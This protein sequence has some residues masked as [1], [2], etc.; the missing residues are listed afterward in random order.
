MTKKYKL[1][2]IGSPIEHSLS[3][4]IQSRFA[5]QE[6]IYI[7]YRPFK[8]E[9]DD[10]EYFVKDFFAD[11]SSKGLNVTLPLKSL[12]YN[13]KG[14]LSKE[15]SQIQAVNTIN[16][17]DRK[18]YLD[19]TDGIGFV[20]DLNRKKILLENKNVLIIG[21][22][23]AV[24]S[25]LFN[26]IQKKPK[27]IF[28]MN[29]TKS[30][31]AK[32]IKKYDKSF[33]LNIFDDHENLFDVI[34]NGSSAGLTGEFKPPKLKVSNKPSFYDLNYSLTST[35]FCQW[36]KEKSE[37]VFDGTGMLVNQAAYSFKIWFG[38]MPSIDKVL[39]DMNNLKND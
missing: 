4:F 26:I 38:V 5:R 27:T 16:K 1:G 7:D 6:N 14:T 31:A 11:S 25:I 35:P 3:P 17:K 33:G 22:G 29:R 21:A 37:F 10:F 18:I 23:A 12:A 20:E 39:N 28:L 30:K 24:E 2:V 34:I 13:L 15:A 9:P 32:L 8:V 36:A 19:S